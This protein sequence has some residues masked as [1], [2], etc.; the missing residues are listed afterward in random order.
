MLNKDIY[1][2]LYVS[3]KL[4][5]ELFSLWKFKVPER[6]P[7]SVPYLIFFGF[8]SFRCPCICVTVWTFVFFQ[9]FN[10][11]LSL[12][13]GQ[14]VLV[15]I[16]QDTCQKWYNKT[17]IYKFS[18]YVSIIHEFLILDIWRNQVRS[19]FSVSL[20]QSCLDIYICRLLY[21]LCMFLFFSL[22]NKIC[23][24]NLEVKF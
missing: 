12:F 8:L 3:E 5:R 23:C 17:V 2:K 11:F 10:L 1:F 7:W 19:G 22:Q 18:F 14:F 9:F 4:A 21:V 13:Y 16:I 20:N 15:K 24:I 6:R